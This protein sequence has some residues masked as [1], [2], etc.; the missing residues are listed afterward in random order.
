MTNTFYFSRHTRL[1]AFTAKSY[2]TTILMSQVFIRLLSYVGKV[3]LEQLPKEWQK[4]VD[5]VLIAAEKAVRF[6][7]SVLP[8]CK[9]H[10]L[11]DTYD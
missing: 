5:D 11:S 10:D 7:S 9:N 3:K 8:H 2:H 1:T 6:T 4:P